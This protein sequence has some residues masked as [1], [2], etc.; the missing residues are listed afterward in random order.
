[1]ARDNG[2]SAGFRT[3]V[4]TIPPGGGVI[5]VTITSPTDGGMIE[6][7]TERLLDGI[8]AHDIAMFQRQRAKILAAVHDRVATAGSMRAIA[9][10]AERMRIADEACGEF[11]DMFAVSA[12]HRLAAT[13]DG[14]MS[15]L[16]AY[17][18]ARAFDPVFLPLMVNGV[19]LAVHAF[20]EDADSDGIGCALRAIAHREAIA[21]GRRVA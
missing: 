19:R 17:L 4:E 5:R 1:M 8:G 9:G 7:D 12:R 15:W 16:R 13:L 20:L 2:P 14:H 18:H 6:T 3:L 11:L 10:D 21:A